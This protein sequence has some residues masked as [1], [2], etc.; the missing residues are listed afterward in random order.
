MSELREEDFLNLLE[1]KSEPK[2]DKV[3]PSDWLNFSSAVIVVVATSILYY[4]GWQYTSTWF[5]FFG[6]DLS[7][8]EIPAST[9]LVNGTPGL[10]FTVGLFIIALLFSMTREVGRS[11][12]KKMQSRLPNFTISTL[13]VAGFFSGFLMFVFLS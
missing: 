7:A 11:R 12:K 13:M 6:L 10:L 3:K 4:S 1:E 8:M 5:S 2:E 9:I